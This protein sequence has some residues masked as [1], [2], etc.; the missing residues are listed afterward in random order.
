M[1]E[2]AGGVQLFDYLV[3]CGH[4][5]VLQ[6]AKNLLKAGDYDEGL[7]FPATVR[8]FLP[9]LLGASEWGYLTKR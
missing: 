6:N 3:F 2:L 1:G 8:H 7:Q 4:L 9:G 5:S